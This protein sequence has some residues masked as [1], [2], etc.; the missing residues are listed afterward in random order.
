LFFFDAPQPFYSLLPSLPRM[1]KD[2][3]KDVV[4][5]VW[6]VGMEV[7]VAKIWQW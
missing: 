6:M 1:D 3:N 2:S 7:K 5:V 4:A